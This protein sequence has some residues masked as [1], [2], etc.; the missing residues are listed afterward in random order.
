MGDTSI[1]GMLLRIKTSPDGEDLL[2]YYKELALDNYNAWK[3]SDIE[4]GDVHKGYAICIDN[5]IKVYEECG[6]KRNKPIVPS[7]Q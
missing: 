7:I 6:D 2:N 3:D 1:K 5:L 4:M